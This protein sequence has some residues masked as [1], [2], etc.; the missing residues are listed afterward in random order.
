VAS[1][2]RPGR[3]GTAGDA[4]LFPFAFMAFARGGGCA[5]F[6]GALSAATHGLRARGWVITSYTTGLLLERIPSRFAIAGGMLL[7]AAALALHLPAPDARSIGRRSYTPRD[8]V[9]IAAD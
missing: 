1:S 9:E 3:V 4:S 6:A 2:T 7:L 5:Q 8:G